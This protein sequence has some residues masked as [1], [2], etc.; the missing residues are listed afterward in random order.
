MVCCMDIAKLEEELSRVI[1]LLYSL[2]CICKDPD[3]TKEFR[4]SFADDIVH[5]LYFGG[6]IRVTCG[7]HQICEWKILV[8]PSGR[9]MF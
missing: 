5:K 8:A 9:C 6:P 1:P 7:G 2:G 4:E 3:L